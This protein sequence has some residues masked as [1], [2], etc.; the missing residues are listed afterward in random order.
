MGALLV[1]DEPQGI[2]FAQGQDPQVVSA[3]P[4]KRRDPSGDFLQARAL[5][6]ATFTTAT[7]LISASSRANALPSSSASAAAWRRANTAAASGR[8]ANSSSL[9]TSDEKFRHPRSCVSP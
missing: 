4:R 5:S 8:G 1:L 7:L 3:F 6:N 2:S 9:S